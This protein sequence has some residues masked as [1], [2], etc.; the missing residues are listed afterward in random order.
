[1]G[2]KHRIYQVAKEFDI[3]NDAL[4]HF[5]GKLGHDVRNH[6]SPVS[7]EMYDEIKKKFSSVETDKDAD[8]DF[9][10]RLK[11][12]HVDA[13]AK[14]VEA[15]KRLEERL[16]AATEFMADRSTIRH[17]DELP[18]DEHVSIES[19]FED[20]KRLAYDPD[21]SVDAAKKTTKVPGS[22]VIK[23]P[24]DDTSTGKEITLQTEESIPEGDIGATAKAPDD[25]K[26][27]AAEKPAKK[28][29]KDE[30]FLDTE[31]HAEK[32]E[33][34]EN[35]PK[36]RLKSEK[37]PDKSI[38]KV[39]L[40]SIEPIIEISEKGVKPP[41][42]K[43]SDELEESE[44]RKKKRKRRR[45]KKTE[46]QIEP[47][48]EIALSEFEVVV[49]K[50]DPDRKK[51][52]KGT[53]K[54]R[55]AEE[56][57]RE[58]KD[59][60]KDRFKKKK[61]KKKP[62]ISEAEVAESIKQTM[63]I[64]EDATKGRKK[65]K[66]TRD[67][68]SD[69]IEDDENLL[70]VNEFSTVGEFA[71]SMEIEANELIRKCIEMGMLVSINQRLDKDVLEMLADEFGF[72][73]EILPEYGHD[74]VEE[75]E[76]EEAEENLIESRAPVVTIM[77]H[78]D[79]GKTSLLD[80]LRESNIIG[81]EAGGITQHIGAYEVIVNGKKITFLDTPGHEAFTAMRARGVQ[82]TD[83]V[84]L[85]VAAD[86]A[87]MPQTIEAINHAQA[88]NVPIIVAIN[89]IDRPNANAE[90]IKKQL[91]DHNV[92]IEEWGGR[93]QCAEISA[94]TGE[95]IPRLLDSILIEADMLELKANFDRLARG[96][97]LESRLDKGKGVVASVLIQKGTL[98]IGQPFIV[99]QYFGKVRSLYNERNQRVKDVYP[100]QPVQVVGFSGLPGAGD[101]FVVLKSEKDTREISLKRQQIR[102]EQELRQTKHLTLDEISR[103]IKQGHL[104]ELIIIVKADV[105][106]SVEALSDSL[107]KLSNEEVAVKV[108]HKGVGAISESDVLLASASDAIIIGFQVRPTTGAREIA[109][110][111]TVDI[112]QYSVIYDAIAEVKS[113]LE[114]MLEPETTE[115]VSGTVEVRQIFKVP[116][117]G[118][119][120]G[121]HVVSG[122]VIR[123]DLAKLYRDDKL[124]FAGKIGSLRR[125][126][127][128]IKEVTAGFECG[129]GFDGFNDIHVN[130]IIEPY[131][132]IKVKRTL[133]SVK[134]A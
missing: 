44:T 7:P 36:L 11:Q 111:E 75:L 96:V 115:E 5:L 81:G 27:K 63:A 46:I 51:Q 10:R 89:K 13:A 47:I 113:A 116:K 17:K 40:E 76:E 85:I 92:L 70:R 104:R 102:R 93:Y 39:D 28:A 19:Y 109:K 94:K 131:K 127:E 110:R 3:S 35:R 15:Q 88:A 117:I 101:A 54:V 9:R 30:K 105:D 49:D 77:G 80:F 2:T 124:I 20:A 87:V 74:L 43:S 71:N 21:E 56:E 58:K 108:I 134:T 122:R 33:S 130:D 91:A 41:V 8:L 26:I 18:S 100:S 126:K 79:H 112:R 1:L 123:N 90:L 103:R 12:K 57:A 128:D 119:I 16:K 53:K 86:D 132:I 32:E 29:D 114:G 4:I 120:A 42:A 68:D 61:K 25:N 69:E 45:K 34:L 67:K 97:I 83:I 95:G 129:V 65:R 99:G 66:R 23:P 50:A 59:K 107:S 55:D 22:K 48:E 106:G 14:Q 125:F 133:S 37:S 84:I 98:K 60:T 64:I 31:I 118:V 52:K 24:K 6:M 121:C 72:Q 82:I 62:Q 38:K 73:I 78:V